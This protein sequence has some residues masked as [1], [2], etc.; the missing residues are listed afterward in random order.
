[1]ISLNQ[2]KRGRNMIKIQLNDNTCL[3]QAVNDAIQESGYKK[4]YIADCLGMTRQNLSK[5]L[6]K[7]NFTVND[8]NRI[9]NVIGYNAI[10]ELHKKD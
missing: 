1:M 3:V 6:A 10:I 8:A 4:S 2:V 7:T 5:M 9:L